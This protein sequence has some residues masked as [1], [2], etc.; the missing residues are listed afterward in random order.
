MENKNYGFIPSLIDDTQYTLGAGSLPKTVLQVNGSWK[1][2][3]PVYESQSEK[4]ETYGCTV[5]G[6]INAIEILLNRL[7]QI[8]PNYSERFTYILAKV[9]EPGAD[10]H[11]ITEI[12]RK[13]GVIDQSLLPMTQTYDEF[14]QPD[15]MTKELVDR[16]EEWLF[17][18]DIKHEWVWTSYQG[19]ENQLK[20]LKEA[21]QYSPVCV[22]VS[23]WA[24]D[25]KDLYYSN[26]PNNHWVVCFGVE[27]ESPL[28]FD[29]YD[30]SIKKLHPDH[31][32]MMAKR[33]WIGESTRQ[34]QINILYEW[35]K[36]L[37]EWV[38]L[39]KKKK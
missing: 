28:V 15:P 31:Q 38:G 17:T 4:F 24:S 10:P 18:Y 34:V 7:H 35:V 12:I 6:T 22:S 14:I 3:L 23:A 21:L 30:R 9:R 33:Y 27:G 11:K 29:S 13:N 8:Q 5:F 25:S 32:I 39:L 2:Y 36:V 26:V 37:L 16:A 1:A 19:K 20:L